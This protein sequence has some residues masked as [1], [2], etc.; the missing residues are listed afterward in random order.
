M[1]QN[2]VAKASVTVNAEPAKVWAAL[3][4]PETIERYMF[5]AKVSSDW[6]VGSTIV[7]RGEWNAK[8]YEDKGRVLSVEPEKLLAY[9][10]YSPLSG[11][12]DQEQNYH[13][14]RIELTE[15]AGHTRI[16][17]SQDRNATEQAR[18]HSEQNWTAMLLGLKKVI[19]A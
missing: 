7:W 15:E 3:V 11:L 18:V 12:P 19:E 4:T 13:T 10:H 14:V 16:A 9:S 2:L 17:L 5:G 6:K 8:P 1:D